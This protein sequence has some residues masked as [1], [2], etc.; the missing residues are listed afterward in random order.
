[1]IRLGDDFPL[2]RGWYEGFHKPAGSMYELF[3]LFCNGK[4]RFGHIGTAWQGI[5]L[6]VVDNIMMGNISALLIQVDN[7]MGRR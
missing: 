6:D 3:Q 5:S 1:M 4:R 2:V 7:L